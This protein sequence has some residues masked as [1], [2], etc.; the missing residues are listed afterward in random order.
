MDDE[1]LFLDEE[2]ENTEDLVT[3]NNWKILIVDDEKE[4]H[5]VT[6]HVL[7]DFHFKDRGLDF[8]H[9]YSAAEAKQV[10]KEHPDVAL[11]FLDV[12]METDDAGLKLIE[13]IRDFLQNRFTRIVLR[14][15]QPGL[16]PEK[17]VIINYDIDDYRSKTELTAVRLF[18][19]TVASLRAFKIMTD[20]EDNRKALE[21]VVKTFWSINSSR[22]AE[23]FLEGIMPQI[24]AFMALGENSFLA[25][26]SNEDD[27]FSLEVLLANGRF[28]GFTGDITPELTAHEQIIVEKALTE[29]HHVFEDQ[30]VVGVVLHSDKE[31]RRL[32]FIESHEKIKSLDISVLRIYLSSLDSAY[33][34]MKL[35]SEVEQAHI[36][37]INMQ[38]SLLDRLNNVISIRSKETAGHVRRV[39][40]SSVYLGR[41]IGL[42]DEFL[43]LLKTASPMH[44]VGKIGV[45][46]SILL[47]PG[48]LTP[49]EREIIKTHAILGREMF[50]D[51]ESPLIKMV[52]NVAG[53]HHE[54]W[55]GTGYPDGLKGND[56]PIAGRITAICD[57]FDALTTERPYKGAIPTD[58]A[59]K[60]M[61]EGHGTHFDPELMDLFLEHVDEF[62][63][64]YNMYDDV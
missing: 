47:K 13:W 16:A 58:D 27:H 56:I 54:K 61:R 46:D 59:L 4:I 40:E 9:A 28:Q 22:T 11:I 8:L 5:M 19:T 49:D 20:Q 7:K 1:I 51:D 64:I 41:L 62:I 57:V 17:D 34:N 55:D 6:T 36:D 10:L 18:T 37:Q 38:R 32:I 50:E 31:N 45:P 23:R 53:C 44:D 12:V 15:G 43:E 3:N 39:A 30:V 42:D 29:G 21:A 25:K 2:S 33:E 63:E 48:I 60:I 24:N 14:T 52:R 26:V 35:S